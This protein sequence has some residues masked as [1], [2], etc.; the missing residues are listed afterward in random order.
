[1]ALDSSTS[2]P[3][4][5]GINVTP[6]VDITLVLLIVFLVTA[7]TIVAQGLPLDVPRVENRQAAMQTTLAIAIDDAGAVSVAGRRIADDRELVRLAVAAK[8]ENADVRVV[9]RAAQSSRHGA[10]VHVIDVL[11]GVDVTR[12]AF[13]VEK[14]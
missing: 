13:A 8:Q 14:K 10:V 4:I 6:L 2:D 7:R 5:T 12:I 11:R 9:I 3:T 1:M